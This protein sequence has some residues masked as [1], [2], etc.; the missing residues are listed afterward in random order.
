MGLQMS[1]T[2]FSF[3][4]F[5]IVIAF[6]GFPLPRALAL[7]GER[8]VVERNQTKNA[9]EDKRRNTTATTLRLI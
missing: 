3:C 6:P 4:A 9:G 8:G 2:N 7:K 5:S 1:R